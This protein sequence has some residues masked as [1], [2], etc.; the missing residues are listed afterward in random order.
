MSLWQTI[1]AGARGPRDPGLIEAQHHMLLERTLAIGWVAFVMIPLALLSY[2]WLAAPA[3]LPRSAVAVLG[4][5]TATTAIMLLTR[6]GWFRREPHLAMFLLVGCTF[7]AVASHTVFID[8][9]SGGNFFLSFFLIGTALVTL[10][11]ANLGWLLLTFA[12]LAANYLYASWVWE[13]LALDAN[14]RTNL[15]FLVYMTVLGAILNRIVCRMF[16]DERRATAELTRVRD[17]LF[18]EM[19]VAKD[20]QTLLVPRDT[21]LPDCRVAGAMVPA[22]AVGGD[23][24]DVLESGGRQFLAIGDVSGHGVT[25]GLTMMMARSSLVAILTASPGAPLGEVYARLNQCLRGNLRRTGL[26]LYMTLVLMEAIGGGRFRA[27][28]GHLPALVRRAAGQV[29]E[30]D[31]PGVWLGVVDDLTPEAVVETGIVLSPNDTLLLYTDGVVERMRGDEL[32]GWERLRAT[33]AAG[34][35]APDELVAAI[36]ADV[37]RFGGE[38]EDDMTVL[39]VRYDPAGA[40]GEGA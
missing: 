6:R 27:V 29:D 5:L 11:P 17:A 21:A 12:A 24:Y 8:R 40:C 9:P 4:G 7:G 30:I 34:P 18:S 37:D 3:A 19:E 32:Y 22:A 14:D 39:A 31:L 16:F 26:R 13:G 38:Q 35:A 15:L 2:A 20:I 33:L 25:T 10:F 28:G 1:A 23:Y 36:L